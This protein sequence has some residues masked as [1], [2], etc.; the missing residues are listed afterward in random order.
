MPEPA[1][2]HDRDAIAV[3]IR[4]S[5]GS[6]Q[7]VGYLSRENALAYQPLFRCSSVDNIARMLGYAIGDRYRIRVAERAGDV[8]EGLWRL[9]A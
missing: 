3:Y 4:E 6:M 1:N 2:K 8:L 9:R 5:E 7:E